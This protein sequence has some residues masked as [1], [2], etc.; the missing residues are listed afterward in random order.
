MVGEMP[1]AVGEAQEALARVAE[2]L[3]SGKPEK[4]ERLVGRLLG[5][6]LAV[7]FR[8][9]RAGEQHGGDGGTRVAG[10]RAIKYEARRYRQKTRLDE[11]GILGEIDQAVTDTPDLEA[12]VLATTKEVSEQTYAVMTR[13]GQREGI[14]V[15]A[16][17]WS[18]VPLP[19]L[20]VLCAS[21]PG[22]FEAE[23]DGGHADVLAEIAASK[24]YEETLSRIR[25]ELESW[26]IGYEL[27]RMASHARLDEIW[28]SR[29]AAEIHFGQDVAGGSVEARHVPRVTVTERLDG[30]YGGTAVD[31]PALVLGQEGMGKTWSVLDW[32]RSRCDELPIVVLVPASGVGARDPSDVLG[33]IGGYLQDLEHG[34]ERGGDYWRQRVRRLLARPEQEGPAFVVYL[35]GLNQRRSYDW[36]VLLHRL[37]AE[38]VGG[39][40]RVIVCARTTFADERLGRLAVAPRRI[41]VGSYGLGEGGEFDQKLALAGIARSKLSDELIRLASV[42]RLFDLVVELKAEL[43]GAEGV[44]KDRLLWKYGASAVAAATGRAFTEQTWRAFVLELAEEHLSGAEVLKARRVSELSHDHVLTQ[45]EV[46][47]R[48]S[49]VRDGVFSRVGSEGEV[50]FEPRFVHYALGLALARRLEA[51]S[52]GSEAEALAGFLEPIAGLDERVEIVRAAVSV[53]LCGPGSARRDAV[54]GA[55][56]VAWVQS[57]E[58]PTEH[59]KELRRVAPELVEGLLDA[60][61]ASGGY[62]LSGP[63]YRA[64]NALDTVDETDGAVAQTIS[65]RAV[66]WCGFLSRERWGGSDDDR[67]NYRFEDRCKRLSERIGT[68]EIGTVSLA[69]RGFEIVDA[70]TRELVVAAA[71]LLQGRPLKHAIAVLEVDAIRAAIDG[72]VEESVSWLNTLNAVDPGETAAL[73]RVRAD[74]MCRMP[75][76]EGV[77]GSLY[78][79]VAALLLWRTG[80][81]EDAK[82]ALGVDPDLDG[83]PSYESEYLA[84]PGESP[85]PLERRHASQVL[86]DAAIPL[87]R[88]TSR[89]REALLDPSLVIPPEFAA[90]AA[91][92]GRR[93]DFSQHAIGRQRHPADSAW[94]ELSLAL[95]RCAPTALAAAERS[96]LQHF[97]AREGEGRLGAAMEVPGALMLVGEAES[98]GLKSLRAR[99]GEAVAGHETWVRTKLLVAEI[100]CAT[101]IEQ[102]RTVVEA[103]LEF[104]DRSLAE[105]CGT[106]TE[107]ELDLLLDQYGADARNLAVISG[108]LGEHDVALSDRA[109]DAFANLLERD[110]ESGAA[111][112]M[113]A[114]NAPRRLAA[115]LDAWGWRWLADKAFFENMMGSHA[116]AVAKADVPFEEFAGRLAPAKLL[117]AL[118][119][120]ARLRSDVEVG[121]EILGR[122]LGAGP[123]PIPEPLV[124][125]AFDQDSS[126]RTADYQFTV[127]RIIEEEPGR[128]AVGHAEYAT[129]PV[130]YETRRQ[131][132][133]R[134]YAEELRRMRREGAH[135]RYV[136]MRAADFGV[137]WRHCPD[138]VDA[139]LAGMEEPSPEFV[140]RARLADGFYVALCGALLVRDPA[141]G[142]VLWEALRTCLGRAKFTVRGDADLLT[143]LLLGAKSC[144]VVEARLGQLYESC[145]NDRELI[146]LVVA[147]RCAQRSEWVA[148]YV[149]RDADSACPVDQLR[150]AFLA[151]LLAAPEAVAES[152]WP[153]GEARTVGD[154]AAMLKQRE[155]FAK[156]W[157][158]R[159]VESE[160]VE[161]AHAAWRL[162]KECADRRVWCWMDEVL[163]ELRARGGTMSVLKLRF[164]REEASALNRA[165]GKNERDWKNT[166]ATRRFPK[167]LR[168]WNPG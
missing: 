18:P 121:I 76:E 144:D 130:N 7:P 151:P 56:C 95:A 23:S 156:H 147:A 94:E 128:E 142:V 48:V 61:E 120:G 96:R 53:V 133:A 63:R 113:L 106:P 13:K 33:L 82:V 72:E 4:L 66:R 69:G 41:E 155:A 24:G 167:A 1:S 111:W 92:A 8:F 86:A 5:R 107:E 152:A 110:G 158:T 37:V 100:Q 20:A 85:Y 131:E 27:V 160:T 161:A 15:V 52:S 36:P 112:V 119:L 126:E 40:A 77:H 135:F 91:E 38:P 3:G 89:A 78:R 49:V 6:L 88:R 98:S 141:R 163:G 30:W 42:P 54:L 75:V 14:A 165:M 146:D 84:N 16:I 101:P 129:S 32:L 159:F 162:F 123:F 25:L 59:E 145:R 19:R 90:E 116:L 97:G 34:I 127:G 150:S 46:Y 168:P 26:T 67:R 9:A 138:A 124:E 166:F 68:S 125:V 65:D 2:V 153:E 140:K 12:W 136:M 29:S 104:V 35:D 114:S 93:F 22:A 134:S 74:A 58:F 80:Y 149:R 45:D 117:M 11:R 64:I 21:D 44:T 31:C 87:W 137:V 55:L 39:R 108:L 105:A 70:R 157:L 71:Q 73:L 60:V 118:S 148:R 99:A 62:G 17:D 143:D 81:E 10:E 122:V 154:L 115:K 28:G 79:R 47:E 132:L 103:G 164:A 139:W 83:R 109:F 50:A 102:I 51:A 43:G 57:Q